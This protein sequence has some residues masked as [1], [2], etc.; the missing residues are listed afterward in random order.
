MIPAL[1]PAGVAGAAA[2]GL[3]YSIMRWFTFYFIAKFVLALGIGYGV[4]IGGNTLTD[5]ASAYIN[6]A[7][8][9]LPADAYQLLSM[10]GFFEGLSIIIAAY[11]AVLTWQVARFTLTRISS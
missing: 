10:C 8:G 6:T 9:G 5:Q 11:S 2:M 7:I 1:I 4:Y 3:I